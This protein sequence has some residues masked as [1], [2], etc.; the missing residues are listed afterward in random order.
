M[1]RISA[2]VAALLLFAAADAPAYFVGDDITFE[3]WDRGT[4][5][6][7]QSVIVEDSE[8]ESDNVTM[9]FDSVQL[10][11]DADRFTLQTLR[12]NAF[13]SSGLFWGY[14]VVG[15]ENVEEPGWILLGVDIQTD[16]AGWSDDRFQMTSDENGMN[17]SFNLQGM[18]LPAGRSL[19]AVFEFGPNPIPIPATAALFVT[20]LVGFALIKRRIHT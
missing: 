20:G 8:N 16:L 3:Y 19:S 15:L 5:R 12:N 1:K 14:R 6:E 2:V 4:L 18:S 10:D 17:L 13:S 9:L 7:S 11:V